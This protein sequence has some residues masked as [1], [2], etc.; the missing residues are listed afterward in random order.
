MIFI[1]LV[2]I[3]TLKFGKVLHIFTFKG[4]LSVI[5]NKMAP[6]RPEEPAPDASPATLTHPSGVPDRKPKKAP[7][8]YSTNPNTV[9]VRQRIANLTPYRA[10][11]ERARSNDLKAVAAA[12]KD[13]AQTESFQEADA[14][15][16]E[17]ILDDV[18]EE[19]LARR[20]RKKID[21]DSKV[22]ALN[23]AILPDEAEAIT[24]TPRAAPRDPTRK[25]SS[26]APPGYV[27]YPAQPIPL[28]WEIPK[29]TPNRELDVI[30]K[31]KEFIK[32]AREKANPSAPVDQSVVAASAALLEAAQEG[33]RRGQSAD[34][35][36]A[37]TSPAPI[38]AVG[39]RA[40]PPDSVFGD[41]NDDYDFLH[42]DSDH[43]HDHDEPHK[44]QQKHGQ[45]QNNI[46]NRRQSNRF[47]YVPSRSPSPNPDIADPA[48][49]AQVDAVVSHM[50]E[51]HNTEVRELRN[52][53]QSMSS[54]MQSMAGILQANNN[55]QHHQQS[56][57]TN[58]ASS[59]LASM[60]MSTPTPT[61][62][63][64]PVPQ[65]GHGPYYPGPQPSA[66]M[67]PAF[68]HANNNNA[69]YGSQQEKYSNNKGGS[70]G[71]RNSHNI[72]EYHHTQNNH[73]E[74]EDSIYGLS[75]PTGMMGMGTADNKRDQD[76]ARHIDAFLKRD[77]PRIRTTIPGPQLPQHLGSTP[78]KP[79]QHHIS[80]SQGKSS[81][82]PES[83]SLFV[84]DNDPN[85]DHDVHYESSKRNH[86][87]VAKQE[88]QPKQKNSKH[89]FSR[90]VKF[91]EVEEDG[92]DRVEDFFS[93]D[94]GDDADFEDSD[95]DAE[96]DSF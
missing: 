17:K 95:L 76:E 73:H 33:Q 94:Q 36:F 81:H 71:L 34:E 80:H 15:T 42:I 7:H 74:K 56:P 46:S 32:A 2:I 87:R 55:H 35:G 10:A 25:R 82:F 38:P 45:N 61:S 53:I 84:T 20:R 6:T 93:E 65:H 30:E 43:H 47:H 44:N 49:V 66:A 67:T 89:S 69:Y 96:H 72:F 14:D 75:S 8:E 59:S 28:L 88:T 48:V 68:S 57:Y 54:E 51:K 26:M 9:R 27:A 18:Q 70:S 86:D 64:F 40:N 1:I 37:S 29:K 50:S 52:L 83:D 3:L 31:S 22:A 13:R 77:C 91:E 16:R 39:D 41:D 58:S 62:A 12:W 23:K 79:S 63:Y 21:A 4:Q 90:S 11:V 60:S 24:G 19:V 85:D 78:L 92:D 5:K